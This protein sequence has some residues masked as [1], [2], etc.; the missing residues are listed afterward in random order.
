MDRFDTLLKIVKGLN[1]KYPEGEDPF[2]IVTRLCE[3]SGE[4]ASEINRMESIGSKIKKRGPPD[5][6]ELAKEVQDVIRCAL[7]VVIHY[8]LLKEFDES[9]VSALT[10]LK[11]DGF[12]D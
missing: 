2:R 9:L 7:A 8:D 5:R 11:K 12:T 1:K 4:L 10:L 3:E 6:L